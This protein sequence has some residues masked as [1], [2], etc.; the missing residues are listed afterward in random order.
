VPPAKSFPKGRGR[1]FLPPFF[2]APTL[3]FKEKKMSQK[4]VF[5]EQNS[6]KKFLAELSSIPVCENCGGLSIK[7]GFSYS[8]Y[9]WKL[10]LEEKLLKIYCTNCRTL[11]LEIPLKQ[12]ES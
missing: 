8:P 7:S 9:Q 1:F 4:I 6:K 2:P 10:E 11:L 3:S 5:V 12:M